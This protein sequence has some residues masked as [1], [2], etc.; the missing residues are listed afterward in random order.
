ML[1]L[2]TILHLISSLVEEGASGCWEN[3]WVLTS[4]WFDF[5]LFGGGVIWDKKKTEINLFYLYRVIWNTLFL[6]TVLY[7]CLLSEILD[8]YIS[9][10]VINL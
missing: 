2:S 7:T 5:V 4:I 10:S 8:W 9:M 6:D 3:D 1:L